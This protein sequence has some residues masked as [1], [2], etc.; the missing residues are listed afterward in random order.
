MANYNLQM[1]KIVN[2]HNTLARQIL[3]LVGTL[4]WRAGT[5]RGKTG[6]QRSVS[7]GAGRSNAYVL[8]HSAMP[9]TQQSLNKYLLIN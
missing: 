4:G 7:G 9:C 6:P 2:F 1:P 8:N 3:S 5:E